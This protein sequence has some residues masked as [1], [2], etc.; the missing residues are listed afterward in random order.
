MDCETFN[1]NFVS[2]P[3]KREITRPW[4]LTEKELHVRDSWSTPTEEE[5]QVRDSETISE[6]PL[7]S[8]DYTS[9][10]QDH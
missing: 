1:L 7:W 9:V 3:Y 6:T 10:T 5:L 8:G 4:F 2:Y